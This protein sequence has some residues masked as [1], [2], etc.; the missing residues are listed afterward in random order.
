MSIVAAFGDDDHTAADGPYARA[1]KVRKWLY[2]FSALLILLFHDLYNEDAAA[3]VTLGVIQL[4]SWLLSQTISISLA[5]LLALYGF[6]A[7]QLYR[8]YDII[9]DERLA[10]RHKEELLQRSSAIYDAEKELE[11]YRSKQIAEADARVYE[12]RERYRFIQNELLIADKDLNEDE[13]SDPDD[14]KFS[15]HERK[16]YVSTL[17]SRARE[18]QRE[19]SKA[20]TDQARISSEPFDPRDKY[21]GQLFVALQTAKSDFERLNKQ[22]PAARRGYK[23]AEKIIDA[24]RLF[25]PAAIALFALSAM[26]LRAL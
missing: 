3:K 26:A 2:I 9:L 22:D 14:L 25:T 12:S 24:A 16:R 8:T 7:F 6:L 23:D 17:N 20:Q 18:A 1:L 11:E 13:N 5:Y 21:A 19:I 10:F 4:P 15:A